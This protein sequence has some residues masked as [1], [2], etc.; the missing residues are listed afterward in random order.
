MMTQEPAKHEPAVLDRLRE[1]KRELEE[2]I[3]SQREEI[4]DINEAVRSSGYDISKI[5]KQEQTN[6]RAS[7]AC[8]LLWLIIIILDLA[9]H[10]AIETSDVK[11]TVII[12]TSV[13][14]L[15]AVAFLSVK[16]CQLMDIQQCLLLKSE[17]EL[18]ISDME[19][20]LVSI[21]EEIREVEDMWKQCSEQPAKTTPSN[22]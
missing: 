11:R 22:T 7:Y 3:R 17:C 15:F 20:E 13:V 6:K 16:A 10:T 12:L 8:F 14:L 19:A 5:D 1:E 4:V 18:C 21:E 2:N 9:N